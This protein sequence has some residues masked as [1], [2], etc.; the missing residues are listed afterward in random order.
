MIDYKVENFIINLVFI[1]ILSKIAST[2]A[3]IGS[4]GPVFQKKCLCGVIEYDRLQQYVVNCT[5][6]GFYDT[7]VLEHM[8]E[9]VAVLIFTGNVLVNLPWNIFGKINEYPNL[10]VI[11]MSNN[12]IRQIRGKSRLSYTARLLRKLISTKISF[13]RQNLSSCSTGRK[14]DFKSQ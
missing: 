4:C 6:A 8:P 1:F 14:V 13:G 7:S 3:I 12:H 2:T 5:N 9:E 11:D 10:K